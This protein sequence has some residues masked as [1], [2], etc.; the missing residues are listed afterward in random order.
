MDWF[1]SRVSFPAPRRR[2]TERRTGAQSTKRAR[3]RR[4]PPV[5]CLLFAACA[6]RASRRVSPPPRG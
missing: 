6:S 4:T 3:A 2:Q 1:F 5:T